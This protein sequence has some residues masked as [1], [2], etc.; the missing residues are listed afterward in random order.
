MR[1]L[2]VREAICHVAV[3]DFVATH[4]SPT[5]RFKIFKPLL[6]PLYLTFNFY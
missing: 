1:E 6:F 2:R 4:H 3:L 5:L